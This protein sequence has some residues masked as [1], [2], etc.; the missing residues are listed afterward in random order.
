M[1]Q[2]D[3]IF[4]N[5]VFEPLSPVDLKEEQQRCAEHRADGYG[6]LGGVDQAR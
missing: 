6:V 5:G 1:S 2:I 3:A 4:R